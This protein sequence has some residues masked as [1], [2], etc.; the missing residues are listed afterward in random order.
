MHMRRQ[1][2]ETRAFLLVVLL[3]TV[4]FAWI[5]RDFLM[6]VFWAVV[7][8]V[9]A[10]PLYRRILR[11]NG[12]RQSLAALLTT[13]VVV[14]VILIPLGLLG[15]A[16]TQ[17]AIGLY[18]RISAG[19]VN[20]QE[21]VDF[22]DRG[23]PAINDL[24]E[25]FG[26]SVASIEDWLRNQAVGIGEWAAMHAVAIGQSTITLVVFFVLMLYF[27]FFFIRDAERILDWVIRALP[28]GDERER[29]L[30]AKFAEVSRATMK[31]TLVVAIVQGGI[32]GILFAIAGINAAIFWGVVM[33]VCSLLPVVGTALVWVPAA[34]ILLATGAVWEGIMILAGGTL[35]VGM[36][37]NFL[38]PV[39]VGYDTK[40][41][42]YLVLLTTLG[43]LA[44]FGLT[45][46]ILGPLVGAMFLVVWEMMAEEYS[47]LDTPTQR[48][49]EPPTSPS[50]NAEDGEPSS[51]IAPD[52]QSTRP[53]SSD[54]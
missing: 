47:G 25:D 19:E 18:Q 17:Q 1:Q 34:I 52:P 28:L 37:D 10:R 20:V 46:V 9:V 26:V 6:P 15:I 8:A 29:R 43:G 2:V 48:H 11:I 32:G 5:V 40:M 16:V 53:I 31:G 14:L 36:V 23:L 4:A 51:A 33:A 42:D 24:L 39:L 35:L 12:D 3:T 50:L 41:P 7:F 22:V 13:L 38:R 49:G 30:F 54:K 21:V 27:L 44:L 45:G